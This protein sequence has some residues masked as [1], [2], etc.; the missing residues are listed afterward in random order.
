[1]K[2]ISRTRITSLFLAAVMIVSLLPAFRTE[3]NAAD[4]AERASALADFA[5][6]Q[7]GKTGRD[8]GFKNEWCSYFVGYCAIS[9]GM[10][11]LFGVRSA[12]ASGFFAQHF[13]NTNK[14]DVY[15]YRDT[16]SSTPYVM[17]NYMKKHNVKNLHRMHEVQRPC[18][19]RKGDIIYF[20][21]SNAASST[22][23]SHVGIVRNVSGGK[24]YYISGNA[25]K[26]SSLYERRVQVDGI[27]QNSR[28]IVGYVRPDYSLAGG[29]PQ[30]PSLSWTSY[31]KQ[32]IGTTNAV[33]ARTLRVS[34]ASINSVSTVGIELYGPGG[35]RLAGKREKP[36]PKDG[37]I[38]MW[39]DVNQELNYKLS[40][41]VNYQ[42]R[43]LA[44]LN[45]KTYY[46]PMY[47]FRTNGTH[48]HT[49]DGSWYRDSTDHWLVCKVCGAQMNRQR[50]DFTWQNDNTNHWSK[51]RCGEKTAMSPHTYG[52]WVVTK[53]PTETSGG[54]REH[55]CTACG[56]KETENLPKLEHKHD[57]GSQWYYNESQHWRKCR[58]GQKSDVSAHTYGNW[59][60]TKE[61]TE[62]SNG[63]R[64]RICTVCGWKETEN[65]P[66][67]EHKHD[68][69]SHWYCNGTQ[70]W[71]ECRC[72]QKSDVS[73]HTYGGWVVTK[74]PT[75]TSDG[76]RERI[77]TV[78]GWK[79]T[80][81]LPKLEHKHD[82]G[83]QWHHNKTQH[84]KECACG[85]KTSVSAH[86]FG[87]WVI[88][89]EPT[90]NAPG[91]SQ[92]TCT[93][94]GYRDTAELPPLDHQHDFSGEWHSNEQQHWKECPCGQT[95]RAEAH[96]YGGW[97][98]I[99]P[100]TGTE[101]GF[102]EHSCTVCGHREVETIP[103]KAPVI[104]FTDVKPDDWFYQGVQYT[105]GR[106]L[107]KGISA[108]EFGPKLPMTRSMVVQVLY[109]MAGKPDV[110]KTHRFPDVKDS[111][112]FSDAV[113]WAVK[114]GVASG[115]GDGRFAPNDKVNRE[116][117]AVMLHGYVGKPRATRQL[118]FADNGDISGW[119]RPAMRWAVEHHMMGGVPGNKILPQGPAERSQGAVIMMNFDKLDK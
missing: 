62:T 43:F 19:P 31:S 49:S 34:N 111:D 63:S 28:E 29:T 39:Y 90:E 101:S 84:W 85:Q 45:G 10:G 37:V 82:F 27:S 52:N 81:N 38:N 94:C 60:V 77:C 118:T 55:T 97:S 106:G 71:R 9:T 5:E 11:D 76:S 48:T 23:V 99:Q 7:V 67:L 35:S 91:F 42:Y 14:G 50:H 65:L 73:A 114:K 61:P 2:R 36:I 21:W 117:L 56:W 53:E 78:C 12:T 93:V 47:E 15:H 108:H 96:T 17:Q 58:C 26:G 4:P 16:T 70:H 41:G 100:P 119:A 59:V 109:S 46:S 87:S 104:S 69:G 80:E 103:P 98:I 102:R 116:Q 1:M 72:G 75:E 66:K 13:L 24:V 107:F 86:T 57:F 51:C 20:R 40:P 32:S 74:E 54:I 88:T 105:V 92:R 68:F 33:L 89:K 25:G 30:Q 112:W 95:S 44:I 79:E 83:S 6:S 113:A 110:E 8:Y 22:T 3:A 115:Y 18:T 64:E